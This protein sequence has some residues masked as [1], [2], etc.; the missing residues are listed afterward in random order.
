M[1]LHFYIYLLTL[2]DVF[3]IIELTLAFMEF[4]LNKNNNDA[5][6][7]VQ[8]SLNKTLKLLC[9]V[10]K[11]EVEIGGKAVALTT[12][13][14]IKGVTK[15]AKYTSKV[16]ANEAEK[17]Y[18]VIKKRVSISDERVYYVKDN[19]LIDSSDNVI[20]RYDNCQ[21]ESVIKSMFSGYFCEI[22]DKNNSVAKLSAK[23]NL[24]KI[25]FRI[26]INDNYIGDID[27]KLNKWVFTFNNWYIK[28]VNSYLGIQTH[29]AKALFNS[30]NNRLF[31]IIRTSIFS[32]KYKIVFEIEP[33]KELLLFSLISNRI[34]EKT[35]DIID[36]RN[37]G[38]AG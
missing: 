22:Y 38:G 32:R 27:S 1:Q 6:D 5:T 34:V 28:P 12:K 4:N 15:V 37:E 17:E 2:L 11:K 13:G 9:N 18:D 19:T 33:N 16:V 20:F 8:E 26:F 23:N 21:S 36:E 35:N 14:A 25:G 3:F 24:V 7:K 29:E 10:V 30:E 31:T